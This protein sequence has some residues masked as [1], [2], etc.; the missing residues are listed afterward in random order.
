MADMKM[1]QGQSKSQESCDTACS[2]IQERMTVIASCGNPVGVVD[3][4]E[5]NAIKL[6]K[7]DSKDGQH[8]FIPTSWVEKVDDQVHLMKNSMEAEQGWKS[9]AAEC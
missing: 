8:H 6:T 5:G 1:K 7:H 4:V 3:H 2:N 9:S